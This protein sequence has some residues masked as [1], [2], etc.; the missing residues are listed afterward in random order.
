MI[1]LLL[2]GSASAC[3][4][5]H[6]QETAESLHDPCHDL[7]EQTVYTDE[8]AMSIAAVDDE[9]VCVVNAPPVAVV[10]KLDSKELRRDSSVSNP[11]Q[12]VPDPE[13]AAALIAQLQPP[14]FANDLS[15]SNAL[16]TLL[17][18]RAPPRL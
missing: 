16:K 14:S 4:C 2:A 1:A 17:P 18:A 8:R 13:F 6:H 12:A 10:A 5:S 7:H 9:C 3:A 11:F 15:Y